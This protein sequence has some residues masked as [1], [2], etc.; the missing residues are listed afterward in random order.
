MFYR[1]PRIFCVA[2]AVIGAPVTASTVVL[3]PVDPV[4]ANGETATGVWVENKGK[5]PV[6]L[7]IRS[8]GWSQTDGQDHFRNQNEVVVSPP[9][10][11]VAAGQRQL[12]RII[13]RTPGSTGSAERSYRLL[14]DEIPPA[15]NPAKPG[16]ATAQLGV[17][18]RY[19]IPL[20]TY[21]GAAAAAVP[22]LHARIELTNEKRFLVISNSGDRHARL[23]DLRT[24]SGTRSTAIV[25]GLVGYVLPGQTA[26]FEL[27]GNIPSVS[28]FQV[29]V[30][31]VDQSL[32]P[33]T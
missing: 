23:L 25:S 16:E 6:T 13:R 14:I 32:A 31:G 2:L 17:Q 22:D 21:D 20:F 18:M 30:N 9:I 7:Q 24:V 26:R 8:L 19:S 33:S 4:I 1:L 12:V 27:P 10:A 15:F 5:E 11:T 28:G 29:N 3:W